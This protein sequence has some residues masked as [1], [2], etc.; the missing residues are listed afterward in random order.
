MPLFT[1]IRGKK[2]RKEWK[3][4]Y[5]TIQLVF[6]FCFLFFFSKKC[7]VRNVV[8]FMVKKKGWSL[9]GHKNK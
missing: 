8:K 4:S 6:S 2:T 9:V 3:E 1:I 5:N 7:E